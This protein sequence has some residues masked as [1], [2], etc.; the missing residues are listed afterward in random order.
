MEFIKAGGSFAI[1]FGK[2]YKLLLQNFG[3]CH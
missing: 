3:N 2:S 1:V